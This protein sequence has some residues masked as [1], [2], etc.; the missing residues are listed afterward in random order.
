MKKEKETGHKQEK[1]AAPDRSVLGAERS[2]AILSAFIDAP[3]PLGLTE[4]EQRTGL[5]KALS[6]AT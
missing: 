6:I 1:D 3:D 5:F 4:L 2:L